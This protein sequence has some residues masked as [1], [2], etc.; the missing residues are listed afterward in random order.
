MRG[1]RLRC[2]SATPRG[3]PCMPPEEQSG[4]R[5]NNYDFELSPEEVAR[6]DHRLRVGGMWDEI[7]KIQFDYLV[8][9]GLRPDSYLLDV[10]CGSLR[11]GIHFIDYLEPHHYFGIDS[12][13]SLVQA[14]LTVEIPAAGL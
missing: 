8:A 12:N 2:Q 4:L 14:G 3:V 10:G 1:V 7:G 6:G 9:Q 13:Q 11:G 5:I